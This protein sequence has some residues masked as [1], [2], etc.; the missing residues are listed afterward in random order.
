MN[1]QQVTKVLGS[2]GLKAKVVSRHASKSRNGYEVAQ[3][4]GVVGVLCGPYSVDDVSKIALDA[5]F[6]V[7]QKIDASRDA[8]FVGAA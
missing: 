2:A 1:H 8:V 3:L 7:Y 4:G 5:G 6:R